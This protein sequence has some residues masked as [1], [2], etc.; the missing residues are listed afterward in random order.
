VV[1][2]TVVITLIVRRR[3]VLVSASESSAR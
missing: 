3:Q 1:A 2:D